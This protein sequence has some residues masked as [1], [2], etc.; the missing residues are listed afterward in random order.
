MNLDQYKI[1]RQQ[2][3]EQEP[4][5]RVICLACRQPNYSCYC[6]HIQKFNPFIKFVIL[7]HPLEVRRRIASGRMSHLCMEDSELIVGGD[8]SENQRVSEIVNDPDYFPV[9]LYPGVSSVNLTPLSFE[10]RA[11]LFPKDKK[12][13]I[14]VIDGTWNTAKKTVKLSKNLKGLPQICFSPPGLSNFRVRTQPKPEC[15]STL[16][17]IHHLL[18]LIGNSCGFDTAS[19][20]HDI[21]LSLFDR[22]VSQQQAH[23]GKR[24]L[25]HS[26][27]KIKPKFCS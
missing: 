27:K 7:I 15:Y 9:I 5:Y 16:E 26:R 12:L 13:V 25:R 8:Y 19:R 3:Q 24:Q 6:A 18:D 14:F 23:V 11:Q 22:L 17:A 2:Q 20:E 10:E 1:N 4:K 21:L